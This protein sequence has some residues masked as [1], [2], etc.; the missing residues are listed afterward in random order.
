[1]SN[2]IGLEERRT[3]A[4]VRRE[5]R[6][7]AAAIDKLRA[8]LADHADGMRALAASSDSGFEPFDWLAYGE[9]IEQVQALSTFVDLGMGGWLERAEGGTD[10]D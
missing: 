6:D 10:T 8:A 7:G 4:Q 1:M 2:V 9:L 5:L 3:D